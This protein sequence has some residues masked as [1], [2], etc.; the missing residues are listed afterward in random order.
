[1]THPAGKS[2]ESPESSGLRKERKWRMLFSSPPSF[3]G[4]FFSKMPSKK[5]ARL[6]KL[7]KLLIPLFIFRYVVFKY[8]RTVTIQGI[9]GYRY[10][11]GPELFDNGT[12][13]PENKCF[14]SGDCVPA[15]A[16]NVSACR[17]GAPGFTSYP[18][19]Y[20]A[21]PSYRDSIEGMKP[22]PKKHEVYIVLEPVRG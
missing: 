6:L 3:A 1:M 19:F 14:C 22:D 11:P 7:S 15:G 16:L 2:K 10:E 9:E 20:E 4:S 12:Y 5:T 17:F 13:N 18:H 8:K 21:D